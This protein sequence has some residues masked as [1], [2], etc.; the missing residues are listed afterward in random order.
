MS[1][2]IIN[3]VLESGYVIPVLQGASLAAGA[4]YM[5]GLCKGRV[6]AVLSV[7]AG[8]SY[9]Y[10]LSDSQTNDLKERFE[11]LKKT[12]EELK[13]RME[14]G[15]AH[16]KELTATIGDLSSNLSQMR[17]ERAQMTEQIT[18]SLTALTDQANRGSEEISAITTLLDENTA[19]V[20]S[21]NEAAQAVFDQTNKSLE[22]SDKATAEAKKVAQEAV[23]L[24]R[25]LGIQ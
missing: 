6:P 17:D 18:Q 24:L 12:N 9:F 21:I 23:A 10:S 11:E 15:N 1:S 20:R 3:N 5:L 2:T 16:A 19:E 13:V 25:S 14:Q 4:G 8:A 22:N 7:L